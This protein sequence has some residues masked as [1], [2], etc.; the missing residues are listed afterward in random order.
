MSLTIAGVKSGFTAQPLAFKPSV[1]VYFG[2]LARQY[3][4]DVGICFS[5]VK[6]FFLVC[7]IYCFVFPSGRHVSISSTRLGEF[8]FFCP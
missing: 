4:E 6:S 8:R 3:L 5:C 1:A 7:F 2:E